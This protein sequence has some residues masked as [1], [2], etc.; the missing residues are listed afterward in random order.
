M[1]PNSLTF[2]TASFRLFLSN[3]VL[4]LSPKPYLKL[5][6]AYYENG[7]NNLVKNEANLIVFGIFDKYFNYSIL[8]VLLGT[9]SKTE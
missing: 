9:I 7:N 3:V 5:L 6:E 4:L 2:E 1:N 8:N